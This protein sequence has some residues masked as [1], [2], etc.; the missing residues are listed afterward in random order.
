M[1][2]K[3]KNAQEYDLNSLVKTFGDHADEYDKDR[4]LA[5]QAVYFN[6]PRALETICKILQKMELDD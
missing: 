2:K 1:Q 3:K 5:E 4:S 6:L